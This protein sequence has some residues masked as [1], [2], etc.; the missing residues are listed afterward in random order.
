METKVLTPEQSVAREAEL[1][2]QGYDTQHVSDGAGGTAVLKKKRPRKTK[3]DVLGTEV[4]SPHR[5]E[6]HVT[7]KDILRGSRRRRR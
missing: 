1:H 5:H 7:A 4:V 6:R 3:G 2:A